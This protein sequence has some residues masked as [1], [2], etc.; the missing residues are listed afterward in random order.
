[1]PA[2][3]AVSAMAPGSWVEADPPLEVTH[4]REQTPE[5]D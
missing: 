1:M 3:G 4:G 2:H 5:Q